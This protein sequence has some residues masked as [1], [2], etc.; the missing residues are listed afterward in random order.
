MFIPL[1]ILL[2]S[3]D[4]ADLFYQ[5]HR[6]PFWALPT[7]SYVSLHPF[8]HML[9]LTCSS[10]LHPNRDPHT[11]KKAQSDN[12]VIH[13]VQKLHPSSRSS[14]QFA[15]SDS[16]KFCKQCENW[17]SRSFNVYKRIFSLLQECG[18]SLDLPKSLQYWNKNIRTLLSLYLSTALEVIVQLW[19]GNTANN[20]TRA[21]IFYQQVKRI[22]SSQADVKRKAQS[23]RLWLSFAHTPVCKCCM[24]VKERSC[25]QSQ[26]Q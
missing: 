2:T 16:S 4:L 25:Q 10:G 21:L 23:S 26:P 24:W 9:S 11:S 20:V 1:P 18:D 12:K 5:R 8:V 6:Q 19:M 13:L 7:D 22:V 14:R 15:G 17:R 3:T